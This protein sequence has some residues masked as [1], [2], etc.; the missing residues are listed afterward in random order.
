MWTLVYL[1]D[2][3]RPST[4]AA[5]ATIHDNHPTNQTTIPI[6]SPPP[7]LSPTAPQ[8]DT[9]PALHAPA[10]RTQTKPHQE[11]AMSRPAT[12]PAITGPD[13]PEAPFPIKVRGPVVRGF[14]RGSKE[15][16][17]YSRSVYMYVCTC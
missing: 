10:S 13:V 15:V 7:Q 3:T 16:C 9:N 8:N 12:R 14:G 2:K 6:P 11:P 1:A 17:S 4:A 5:A